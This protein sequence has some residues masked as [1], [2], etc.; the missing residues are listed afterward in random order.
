M[1]GRLEKIKRM[2]L[3]DLLNVN[4]DYAATGY[5]HLSYAACL[6]ALLARKRGCDMELCQAAGFLH[7]VWLHER[8]P[9]SQADCD[10]HAAEGAKLARRLMEQEGEFAPEEIEIVARMIENH[11]FT[12][13][14]DDPMS[15]ILKDA[16][17]LSHYLN[18]SALGREEKLNPRAA[19]TL[20]EMHALNKKGEK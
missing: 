20:E 8:A 3:E 14:T 1:S 6:G 15:E 17:M 7:D 13:Q 11:D 2:A 5:A 18:A 9:Y 4:P 10:A 12:R 16:D 19:L